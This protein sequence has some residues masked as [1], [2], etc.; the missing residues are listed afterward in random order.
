[1]HCTE[2]QNNA[3]NNCIRGI[4]RNGRPGPRCALPLAS[5][6]VGIPPAGR[7]RSRGASTHPRRRSHG[8]EEPHHSSSS[9]G[10]R[11]RQ[12]SLG[13]GGGRARTPCGAEGRRAGRGAALGGRRKVARA[14]G[15]GRKIGGALGGGG[16]AGRLLSGCRRR[17]QVDVDRGWRQEV[18][19]KRGRWG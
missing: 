18:R 19:D 1:M 5:G 11:Q 4:G 9:L 12:G 3:R 13:S 7:C 10:R 2:L 17:R 16:Q 15:W 8:R 14:G 6:E